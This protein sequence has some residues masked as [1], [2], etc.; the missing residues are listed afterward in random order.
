MIIVNAYYEE[1]YNPLTDGYHLHLAGVVNDIFDINNDPQLI[2][3]AIDNDPDFNP[4]A[5]Q[6]YEIQL[7]RA[8]IAADPIPEHALTIDRVI[9]KVYDEDRGWIT[10]IVRH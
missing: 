6:F 5:G 4:K 8:T 9:E 7:I 2:S 3:E 1:D 10:P